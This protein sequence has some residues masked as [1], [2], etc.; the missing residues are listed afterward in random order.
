MFIKLMVIFKLILNLTKTIVA[1]TKKI[2]QTF[3]FIV[4]RNYNEE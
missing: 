3:K 4:V 2:K 1:K